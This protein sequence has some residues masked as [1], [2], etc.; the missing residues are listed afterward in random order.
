MFASPLQLPVGIILN[1]YFKNMDWISVRLVQNL[2][3]S[4]RSN[5]NFGMCIEKRLSHILKL[6]KE[7]FF[8]H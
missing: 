8:M 6:V 1:N 2:K 7:T 5:V 3:Y 4:D